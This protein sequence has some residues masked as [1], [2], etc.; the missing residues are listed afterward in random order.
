MA[1]EN[2]DV[3]KQW[4]LDVVIGCK[5]SILKLLYSGNLVNVI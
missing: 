2:K 4:G 1:W 5:I 3:E